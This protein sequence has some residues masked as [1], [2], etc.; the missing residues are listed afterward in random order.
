MDVKLIRLGNKGRGGLEAAHVRAVA[1]LGLGVAAD[2]GV[3]LGLVDPLGLLLGR[4]LAEQIRDEHLIVKE[5]LE[6]KSQYK[7]KRRQFIIQN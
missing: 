4:H 7:R 2:D 1:E 3:I 6:R 5:G